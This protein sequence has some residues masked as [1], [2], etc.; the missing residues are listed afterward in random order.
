MGRPVPECSEGRSKGK[1]EGGE[2]RTNM[3]YVEI[4]KTDEVPAGTM[5]PFAVGGKEILLVNVAG[6]YSA[7]GR[8]CA[9]R[10]GDLS[11]GKLEGGVITCPACP[12]P[13]HLTTRSNHPPVY[14]W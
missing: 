3:E 12:D 1:A 2:R 10:G 6:K 5:K 7:I 11:E 14:G 9:H 4:A 8:R 13:E